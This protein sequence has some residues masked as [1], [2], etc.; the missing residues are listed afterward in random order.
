ML[1]RKAATK[2]RLGCF[3][4][5]ISITIRDNYVDPLRRGE[6]IMDKLKPNHDTIDKVAVLLIY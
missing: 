1:S 5:Q 2:L 3:Q 6:C 4:R